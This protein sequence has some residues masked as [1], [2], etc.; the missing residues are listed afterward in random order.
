MTTG[1]TSRVAAGPAPPDR[2]PEDDTA[3]PRLERQVR[4]GVIWSAANP[5]GMRLGNI[6]VMVVVVRLVTP[7]EFRVFAVALTVAGNS[8]QLRRLGVSEF[9]IRSDVDLDDVGPTVAFITV[10]SGVVLTAVTVLLAP[11]LAAAFATPEAVTDRV[12]GA[13]PCHRIARSGPNAVLGRDFR[14]DRIFPSRGVAFVPIE[15]RA[16]RPRGG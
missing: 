1:R 10:V 4:S 9:L 5:L 15:C 3:V 14:Q 8:R 2:E 12:D 6:A 16:D 11:L 13:V 7:T